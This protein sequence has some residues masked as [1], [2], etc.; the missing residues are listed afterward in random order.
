MCGI[1]EFWWNNFFKGMKLNFKFEIWENFY[2]GF[3]CK[4]K[5]TWEFLLKW[6]KNRIQLDSFVKF[7][8]GGSRSISRGIPYKIEDKQFYKGFPY[9]KKI[10]RE[11]FVIW[12]QI[13]SKENSLIIMSYRPTNRLTDRQTDRVRKKSFFN[14]SETWQ[15]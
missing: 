15:T 9:E 8:V 7:S 14:F 10:I 1:F 4:K 6:T 13:K 2:K 5:I 3:P 11:L 12:S